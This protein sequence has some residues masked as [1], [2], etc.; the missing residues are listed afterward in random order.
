LGRE[1]GV[2]RRLLKKKEKDRRERWA[3]LGRGMEREEGIQGFGF[4]LYFFFLFQHTTNKTKTTKINATLS[5]IYL[6]YKN[7]QLIFLF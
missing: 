5:L 2:G 3:K 6:I 7:N 1:T 4:F